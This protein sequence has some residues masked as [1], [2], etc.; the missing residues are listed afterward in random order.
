MTTAEHER[1]KCPACHGC[2]Y[3]RCD[4]WPGDCICGRDDERCDACLG[5]GDSDWNDSWEDDP[6]DD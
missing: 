6:N 3:T 1:R 4:C 5:T 2:G